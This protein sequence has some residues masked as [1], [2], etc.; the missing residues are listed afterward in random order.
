MRVTIITSH[1]YRDMHSSSQ[2]PFW[3]YGVYDCTAETCY[4]FMTL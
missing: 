4:E 1:L 2:A 3:K